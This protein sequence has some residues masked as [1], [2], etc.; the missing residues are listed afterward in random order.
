MAT[1]LPGIS[2]LLYWND[3]DFPIDHEEMKRTEKKGDNAFEKKGD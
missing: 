1:Q 3:A 2:P